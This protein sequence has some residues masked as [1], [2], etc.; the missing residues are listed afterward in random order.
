MASVLLYISDSDSQYPAV[1][2]KKNEAY[3]IS[4]RTGE[5]DTVFHRGIH[6]FSFIAL[7]LGFSVQL[8]VCLL[9]PVMIDEP[10]PGEV[11]ECVVDDRRAM[12]RLRGG[13]AFRTKLVCSWASRGADSAE[14]T[15]STASLPETLDSMTFKPRASAFIISFSSLSLSGVCSKL[16]MDADSRRTIALVVKCSFWGGFPYKH[17]FPLVFQAG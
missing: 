6:C 10:T 3:S 2:A 14:E 16:S 9:A 5:G 17:V 4:I 1:E 15:M 7:A 13:L 11:N 12:G 8:S